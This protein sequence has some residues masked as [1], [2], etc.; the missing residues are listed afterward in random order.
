VVPNNFRLLEAA[1]AVVDE[2]NRLL[3]DPELSVIHRSQLRD[4]AQSITANIREAIGRD[5]GPDRSKSYRYARG[6]AEETDEHL[7]SNF[8]DER[9]PAPVYWR[10]HNRLMVIV[11]MLDSLTR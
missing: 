11:K 10:L 9:I 7:R 8:R 6:S 5:I 3:R 2:I 4:A 1:R